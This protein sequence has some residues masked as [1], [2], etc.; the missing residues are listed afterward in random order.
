MRHEF[1]FLSVALSLTTKLGI[2]DIA[3]LLPSESVTATATKVMYALLNQEIDRADRSLELTTT[4]GNYH[5]NARVKYTRL[6]VQEPEYSSSLRNP[7]S[8]GASTGL[9]RRFLSLSN[10]PGDLA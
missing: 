9:R 3:L 10:A 8:T 4:T 7:T 6:Q 2:V 1:E 5:Y